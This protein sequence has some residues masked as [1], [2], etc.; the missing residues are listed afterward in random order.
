MTPAR[1]ELA[2]FLPPYQS[3]YLTVISQSKFGV[4]T[5]AEANAD[6]GA[7]CLWDGSSSYDT[8]GPMVDNVKLCE[9]Q[10]DCYKMV[11]DGR[12]VLTVD[13]VASALVQVNEYPGLHVT[14]EA[15]PGTMDFNSFPMSTSLDPTT[16]VA[17]T[18]WQHA[19]IDGV[20]LAS[21]GS[22]YL[23]VT[24]DDETSST[25]TPDTSSGEYVM[26]SWLVVGMCMGL[27]SIF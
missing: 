7:V 20:D 21:V 22:E 15:I 1:S 16:K 17:L 11:A 27:V 18:L 4:K 5:I 10:S 9:T 3:I 23:D 8:V 12:C 26:Q 2:T 19:A 14:K 13:G 25:S 24:E 6:K